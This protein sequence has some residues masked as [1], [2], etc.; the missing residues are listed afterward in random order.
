[1]WHALQHD[2]VQPLPRPPHNRRGGIQHAL[3]LY[4][5]FSLSLREVDLILAARGDCR[6]KG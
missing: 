3:W 4:H 1:M 5:G 2:D 6:L